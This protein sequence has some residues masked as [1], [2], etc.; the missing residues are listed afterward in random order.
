MH[1][2]QEAGFWQPSKW[3]LV[4]A[5]QDPSAQ[6]RVGMQVLGIRLSR[7]SHPKPLEPRVT[8]R[9]GK[10]PQAATFFYPGLESSESR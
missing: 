8:S 4:F 7:L 9:L 6:L 2:I 1:T 10:Q 3:C 5:Q